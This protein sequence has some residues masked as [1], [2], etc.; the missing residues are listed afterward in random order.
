MSDFTIYFK[1]FSNTVCILYSTTEY[2]ILYS[3]YITENE[4]ENK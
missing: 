1:S 4:S 3:R 2:T